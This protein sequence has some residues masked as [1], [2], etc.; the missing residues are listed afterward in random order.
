M[1]SFVLAIPMLSSTTN[2]FLFLNKCFSCCCT[3]K[4]TISFKKLGKLSK[5]ICLSCLLNVGMYILS[6]III[7][8]CYVYPY[9]NHQVRNPNVYRDD[10]VYQHTTYAI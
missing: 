6:G 3:T 10:L 9:T 1:I 2:N 8:V 5:N 4:I 7:Y